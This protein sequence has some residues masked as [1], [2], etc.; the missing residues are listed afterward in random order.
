[1][2]NRIRD[3]LLADW[4]PH[5]AFRSE[6]AGGTYDGYINPILLLVR[7]GASEEALMDWL[8]EKERET[9]CFPSLG[10]ER[11]R[12]VAQNLIRAVT[13]EEEPELP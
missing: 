2:R 6:A 13:A 8:Q 11:L 1:M 5:D 12:R 4:D 9:M 10:K 3:V 7:S